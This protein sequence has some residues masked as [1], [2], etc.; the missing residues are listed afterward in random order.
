MALGV[1][2]LLNSSGNSNVGVCINAGKSLTTGSYNIAP[3]ETAIFTNTA[4]IS[5][6]AIGLQALYSST[7]NDNVAI[8]GGHCS[9]RL[10]V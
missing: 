6:V 5:N 2:A 4:G 3:G 9:R 1:N 10:L 7:S 8:G